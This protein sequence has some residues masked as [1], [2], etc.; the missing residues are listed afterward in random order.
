M[1]LLDLLNNINVGLQNITDKRQHLRGVCNEIG[2]PF[3]TPI[4]LNKNSY[5]IVPMDNTAYSLAGM[6]NSAYRL[7]NMI[8]DY[9]TDMAAIQWLNSHGGVMVGQV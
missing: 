4:Q 6:E 2:V 5:L 8:D 1:Y 9:G 7:N 3:D